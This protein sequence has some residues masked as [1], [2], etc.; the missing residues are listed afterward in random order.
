VAADPAGRYVATGDYVGTLAIYDVAAQAWK[1][2]CRP[3]AHGI[4]A[5]AWY[6]AYGTFVASS[7]DGRVYEIAP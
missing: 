3:T 2:T 6:D 1:R 4:S 5:L 7:Y